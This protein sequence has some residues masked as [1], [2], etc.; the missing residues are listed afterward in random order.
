MA[1]CTVNITY[2]GGCVG[3]TSTGETACL[4]RGKT[5]GT[6]CN[7]M[8]DNSTGT[9]YGP[10]QEKPS[11][12]TRTDMPTTKSGGKAVPCPQGTVQGGIDADGVP[13][14]IGSGADPKNPPVAP[15]TT[16]GPPVTT[17]NADGSST[18]TQTTTQQ[19]SDGSTTTTV[20]KTIVGADGAKTV[21]QTQ[22][23]GKS[24]SGGQGKMDTPNADQTNLCKQNPQLAICQ[25]STVSG[26]CSAGAAALVC[27]GDAVQC[28]QLRYSAELACRER[29]DLEDLKA[30]GNKSLGDSILSGADPKK[31]DIDNL[32]KGTE[33]DLS[34]P[35]LD[36]SGFLGGG[37]CLANR[38]FTVLG[39]TVT[40]D[41]ST[42]CNNI[43]PFRAGIM[44][45]A[46]IVAYMLVSRSVLQ[47]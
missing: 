22:D 44:L 39:Q 34:K 25:N 47:S 27:T 43:L 14:C 28:A 21:S 23:T 2:V 19:N 15:P 7:S 20:V 6:V 24:T 32:L 8:T 33:V 3:P 5:T 11:G 16:T 40:M 1:G 18:T 13:L 36:Q 26:D 29:Q 10:G 37:S 46:F 35:N 31:A 4:M 41:F 45:C 12:G 38:N 17:Q 9:N 30:N 42:V